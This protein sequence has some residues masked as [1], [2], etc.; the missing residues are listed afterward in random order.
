MEAHGESSVHMMPFSIDFDGPAPI[1]SFFPISEEKGGVKTAYFRGRE[2]R[3]KSLVLPPQV[4]GLC[5]SQS[6]AVSS[7]SEHASGASVASVASANAGKVWRADGHF[8]SLTVWQHDVLPDMQMLE[9]SID[10]FKVAKGV[11]DT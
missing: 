1:K 4:V 11:H 7:N 3:G 2:M 5:M 6:G 10:W 9:D 8:N